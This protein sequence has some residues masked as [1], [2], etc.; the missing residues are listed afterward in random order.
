MM[1]RILALLAKLPGSMS[2]VVARSIG[3]AAVAALLLAMTSLVQPA[4]AVSCIATSV[5]FATLC[6]F[7][8]TPSAGN[9]T[10]FNYEFRNSSGS[11][12]M[13]FIPLLDPNAIV[14]G[15]FE[16]NSTTTTPTIITGAAV[17]TDWVTPAFVGDKSAFNDPAA[18]IEIILSTGT[19]FVSYQSNDPVVQGPI[20]LGAGVYNDPPLPGVIPEPGSL[21]LFG[22]ALAGLGLRR[23]RRKAA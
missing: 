9:P 2:R 11:S 17:T 15:S 16:I 21:V 18:L 6:S 7:G 13:V 14:T 1:E 23:W 12:E 19:S 4:A 3:T 10:T 8:D 5:T 22:T 20:E